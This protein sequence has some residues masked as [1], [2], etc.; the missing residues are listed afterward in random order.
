[1]TIAVLAMA[2]LA[3]GCAT[4]PYKAKVLSTADMACVTDFADV[5]R[6]PLRLLDAKATE[7]LGYIEFA[8][9]AQCYRNGD[10]STP[11]ALYAFE[12]VNPPAE[13]KVSVLLSTGGTFA[14]AVDVLDAQFKTLQHHR[15]DAFVRRGDEYSLTVFLNPSDPAPAYLMLV[16]DQTQVGKTDIAIG[17]AASPI[18]IPAGPVM[19]IYNNGAETSAVREFMAGGKLKVTVK[20]QAMAAFDR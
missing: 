5:A 10:A 14:A 7:K 15:F 20:P 1:M 2:A 9:L 11:L 13:A 12:G 3:T 18:V 16:P 6:K 19:F 17:S 4:T 8:D